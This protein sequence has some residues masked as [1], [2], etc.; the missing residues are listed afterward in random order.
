MK[1]P[2]R[3]RERITTCSENS[4]PATLTLDQELH[5]HDAIVAGRPVFDAYTTGR[6]I[7]KQA[8]RN[9]ARAIDRSAHRAQVAELNRP[10]PA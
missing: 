10:D 8:V 1:R 2:R 4:T 6:I 9:M 7:D 3:E 5:L